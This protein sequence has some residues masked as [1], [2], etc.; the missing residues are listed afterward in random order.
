M[1]FVLSALLLFAAY[2]SPCSACGLPELPQGS[3]VPKTF[4]YDKGWAIPGLKD[5]SVVRTYHDE[6]GSDVI[7]Y[8]LAKMVKIALQ[9]FTSSPD[10]KTLH[11]VPGYLQSVDRILEYRVQGRT[12]AY[13][14]ETYSIEEA[15][16]PMWQQI[17]APPPTLAKRRGKLTQVP[18]G[19]L[20]CGP[21]FLRYIDA[22]GDGRFESMEY[23][24]FGGPQTN[25]TR[26]P[27][28]PAWALKLL[29]NREAAERCAKQAAAGEGTTSTIPSA[30]RNLLDHTPAMP[31]LAVRS[32]N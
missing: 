12:Y 31:V 10:G 28:T 7:E 22:D 4:V 26:C 11:L 3:L 13:S 8:E 25:S 20:G 27:T 17:Q 9:G 24:G 2:S 29:P 1:R 30:L 19:L 32:R 15:K 16:P 6:T 18:A 5:A 14:V 21:T 23:V